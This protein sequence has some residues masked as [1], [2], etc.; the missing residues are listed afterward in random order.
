MTPKI[1]PVYEKNADHSLAVSGQTTVLNLDD[2][3]CYHT[4]ASAIE[5]LKF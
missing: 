2:Y 4:L 3:K 5:L 1:M